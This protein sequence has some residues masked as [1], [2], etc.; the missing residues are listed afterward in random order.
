VL[1][2][3]R[4]GRNE[5]ATIVS[6]L[7][8]IGMDVRTAEQR[9]DFGA[10]VSGTLDAVIESGVPGSK[11]RHVA[12]FKTHSRKSFEHLEANGFRRLELRLEHS[13]AAEALPWRH[14]D[15]VDRMLVAQSI[16]EPMAL[17]DL[18][19]RLAE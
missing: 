17:L 6:D 18:D 19:R 3:F 7:R 16:V 4:R 9:V 14:R 10:H 15:P 13:V 5:E 11:K 1:R 8:A 12:E 2:L